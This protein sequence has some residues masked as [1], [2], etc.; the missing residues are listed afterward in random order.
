ME[1]DNILNSQIR[2]AQNV[3]AEQARRQESNTDLNG[4]ASLADDF[5]TFLTLLTT[6]LQNQDPLEPTDTKDFTNQLVQFSGV[7][8]QISTNDKLD[9]VLDNLG[10]G[11]TNAAVSM[12]GKNVE[13]ESNVIALRD[14]D[15]E[16]SVQLDGN[17]SAAAVQ[18]AN[19]RGE[20]VRSLDVPTQAGEHTVVWDG[21]D[22]N[23]NTVEDGNFVM[24]LQAVDENGSSVGGRTFTIGEV[25][26]FEQ[27]DGAI[28]LDLGGF[29]VG[30]DEVRSVL[31]GN[32]SA[33]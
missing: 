15:A 3:Q 29:S 20:V 6:Q 32:A 21:T 12:I 28:D 17:A 19:Q 24:Q 10:S 9:S 13:A 1:S 23:G 18:I 26:G 4:G 14:G 2:S 7:E 5:S 30:L 31:A 25:Q 33:A 16:L 8:Q 11:R 22:N 27:N